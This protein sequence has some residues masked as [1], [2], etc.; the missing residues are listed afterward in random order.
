[1]PFVFVI[2]FAS[3]LVEAVIVAVTTTIATKAA[4]DLYDAA[5]VPKAEQS[6]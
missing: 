4:A 6:E 5:F 1:M 2:P 3:T